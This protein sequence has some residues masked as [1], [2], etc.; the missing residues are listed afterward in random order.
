MSEAA[1]SHL[2]SYRFVHVSRYFG[3]YSEMPSCM[4]SVP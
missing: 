1:K 2:D 3:C 4:S